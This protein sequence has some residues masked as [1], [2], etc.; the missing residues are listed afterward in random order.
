MPLL[1]RAFFSSG[2]G[3]SWCTIVAAASAVGAAPA[4]RS[5]SRKA[6]APWLDGQPAPRARRAVEEGLE[7]ARPVRRERL[8]P[9]LV[10]R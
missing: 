5:P 6:S 4:A 1:A 10:E 9:E 8:A 2:S 3:S 7:V